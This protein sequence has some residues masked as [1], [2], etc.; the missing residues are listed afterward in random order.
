VIDAFE[1][2]FSYPDPR[3]RRRYDL[4]ST[5]TCRVEIVSAGYR[6][7]PWLITDANP[8]GECLSLRLRASSTHAFVFADIP[9]DK[10]WLR[11]HVARAAGIERARCT[12][13]ELV[14][15]LVRVEISHVAN[16]KGEIRAVVRKWQPAAAAPEHRQGSRDTATLTDAIR[17]WATGDSPERPRQKR[18]QNAPPRH[19]AADDLPF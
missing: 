13:A 7:V 19:G 4:V 18:S 10:P 8:R 11:D 16:R 3:P 1:G 12:P 15:K 9:A 2:G 14:G 6:T 5:G 17:A